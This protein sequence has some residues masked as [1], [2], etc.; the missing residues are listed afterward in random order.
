MNLPDRF[1]NWRSIDGRKVPCR[2][3]GTVCDAHDPANHTDYATAAAAPYSV[4]F[5]IR[6]ED[7]LFFLDMDKCRKDDGSWTAEAETIFLSFAGAWGE[8][9]QS[10]K[11]LHIIGRCDPSKLQ[12]R[13]NKFD[14]WKEFY[15]DGRFVAFGRKGWNP[16]GGELRWDTDWTDQLLRVVPERANLGELPEGVD[17]AYT[18]PN[19]DDEL[20]ETMLASKGGAGAKFGLKATVRDLWE[21]NIAVLG[22][23]YP[24][25]DGKG[26]FDHSSADAALMSHLAFWTGKDMPRM[27]RLFRRSAL[28]PMKK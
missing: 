19:D 3:D 13:R 11:G 17:P 20:I 12:D 23:M 6:A 5:D 25:Y 26:D 10:G 28:N 14:G 7:G 4:A 15:T 21:A 27:D 22:K 18:G 24:A 2:A 8:V 1:L 9:S 16:I